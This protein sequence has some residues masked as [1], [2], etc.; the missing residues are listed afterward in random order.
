MVNKCV[1]CGCSSGYHTNREKVSTFSLGKSDLLEKWVKFFYRVDWFLMK[2]PVLCIKH[3][4]ENL[5]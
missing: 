1:A 5:L 3:F 4:H 2:N